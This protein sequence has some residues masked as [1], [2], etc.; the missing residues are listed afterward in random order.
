MGEKGSTPG[1]IVLSDAQRLVNWMKMMNLVLI[2]LSLILCV[3]ITKRKLNM[4]TTKELNVQ[5]DSGQTIYY[6]RTLAHNLSSNPDW[7]QNHKLYS[8]CPEDSGLGQWV[9]VS[10]FIAPTSNSGCTRE[11]RTCLP[12]KSHKMPNSSLCQ[13]LSFRAYMKPFL[14]LTIKFLHTSAYHL[15]S[16][17]YEWWWLT[18]FA[19][20]SVCS[21]L[22][23]FH[24]FPQ[25][26]QKFHWDTVDIACCHWPR[27]LIKSN[28]HRSPLCF[29][30]DSSM[31]LCWCDKSALDLKS[32]FFELSSS[33]VIL[34]LVPRFCLSFQF[35]WHPW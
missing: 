22:S 34:S 26:Y 19:M 12:H 17:I 32:T 11:S 15:F 30:A 27:N 10:L 1:F 23:G 28:I 2:R 8:N 33:L 14:S 29:G 13:Q 21:H 20:A 7:E 25:F 6:N 31:N 3:C 9:T 24:L 35:I 4:K 5:T 16:A 18:P